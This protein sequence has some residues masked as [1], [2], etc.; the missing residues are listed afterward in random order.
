MDFLEE[1]LFNLTSDLHVHGKRI[2]ELIG[3]THDSNDDSSKEKHIRCISNQVISTDTDGATGR[4][5]TLEALNTFLRSRSAYKALREIL[6]L[7]SE[8]HL[9]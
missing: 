3:A 4:R 1:S 2:L 7:P 5:Y 6:V 8:K 9:K